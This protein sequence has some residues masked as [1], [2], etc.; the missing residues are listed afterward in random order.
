MVT[1]NHSGLSESEIEALP[2][3][4]LHKSLWRQRDIE[5][6]EL[7]AE[8]VVSSGVTFDGRMKVIAVEPRADWANTIERYP[9][10]LISK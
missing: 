2:V 7:T 3:I 1:H 8:S 10:V 6:R 9:A 5:I 4:G